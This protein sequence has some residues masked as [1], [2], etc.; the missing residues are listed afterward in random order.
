[1]NALIEIIGD[2][3]HHAALTALFFDAWLKSLAV[4]AGD[5]ATGRH[6][7][8]GDL[9]RDDLHDRRTETARCESLADLVDRTDPF[10]VLERGARRDPHLDLAGGHRVEGGVGCRPAMCR[11]LCADECRLAARGQLGGEEAGIEPPGVCGRRYPASDR[12]QGA[13]VEPQIECL[14]DIGHAP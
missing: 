1:M 7:D 11:D 4:L 14:D 12:G 6:D 2:W 3:L 9:G 5:P 13:G 10:K 8:P